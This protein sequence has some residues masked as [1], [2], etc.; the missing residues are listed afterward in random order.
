[1]QQRNLGRSN[2][3]V[4]AI[5]LGCMSMS[6]GLG[7]AM[8]K[9]EAFKLIDGEAEVERSGDRYSPCGGFSLRAFGA[10]ADVLYSSSRLRI[11]SGSC[12]RSKMAEITIRLPSGAEV[13]LLGSL[14]RSIHGFTLNDWQSR[15]KLIVPCFRPGHFA[16]SV[17]LLL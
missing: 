15:R 11:A 12:R 4:S 9:N 5:G 7:P 2:L 10:A 17:L 1:M 8:D 6:F 16:V 14:P 3:E 13:R